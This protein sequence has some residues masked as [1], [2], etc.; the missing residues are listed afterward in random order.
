M[1]WSWFSYWCK[2]IL[3]CELTWPIKLNLRSFAIIRTNRIA[4]LPRWICERAYNNL[5]TLAINSLVEGRI[6]VNLTSV[7]SVLLCDWST[8]RS[9]WLFAG[10]RFSTSWPPGWRNGLTTASVD[11]SEFVNLHIK[12]YYVIEIF[13]FLF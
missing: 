10:F 2:S 7:I 13:H 6:A 5:K 3:R 1:L 11:L 9:I 12:G 4:F 8:L